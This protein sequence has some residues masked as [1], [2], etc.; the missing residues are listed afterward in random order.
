MKIQFDTE[1]EAKEVLEAER[2]VGLGYC[3][4]IKDDCVDNCVCYEEGDIHEPNAHSTQWIVHYPCCTNLL[5]VCEI[6]AHVEY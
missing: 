5:M 1:K 4:L 3:P 6:T 2:L